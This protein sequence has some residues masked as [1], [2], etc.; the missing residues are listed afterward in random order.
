ME[1]EAWPFLPRCL[2]KH[3]CRGLG[4]PYA[5]PCPSRRQPQTTP[6]PT[7]AV[8]AE[9]GLVTKKGA[10]KEPRSWDALRKGLTN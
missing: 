9:A 2:L 6:N 3:L 5:W 1:A 8:L 10:D 7:L 4:P